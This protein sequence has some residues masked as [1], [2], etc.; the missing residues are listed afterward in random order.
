MSES[1]TE[2]ALV[3][4]LKDG[5][6]LFCCWPSHMWSSEV[7]SGRDGVFWVTIIWPFANYT[8]GLVI[9]PR[10]NWKREHAHSITFWEHLCQICKLDQN[11]I[12]VI[13]VHGV[14]GLVPKLAEPKFE[15]LWL[16]LGWIPKNWIGS[17]LW[18]PVWGSKFGYAKICLRNI[19][20]SRW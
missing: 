1:C 14:F 10:K 3:V 9:Y 2:P 13:G 11:D 19:G 17:L 5:A 6:A 12:S 7:K 8:L 4:S 18:P 16:L 15:K 20:L